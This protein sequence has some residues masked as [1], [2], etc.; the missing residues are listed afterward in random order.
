MLV[1]LLQFD[2]KRKNVI[3]M[4]FIVN[5]H[6]TVQ[7]TNLNITFISILVTIFLGFAVICYLTLTR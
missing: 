4:I 2:L 3:N 1:I 7:I 5:F 6:K